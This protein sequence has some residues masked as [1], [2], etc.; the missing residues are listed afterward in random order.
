[1]FAANLSAAPLAN[2]L[3]VEDVFSTYLYTGNGSTQTIN[4]G[5]D[6]AGKGG[7]VWIKDR[8]NAYGHRLFN[9]TTGLSQ[10]LRSNSTGG[11]ATDTNALTALSSGFSATSNNAADAIT[12]NLSPFV[13]WT[14]RKAPKFFDVVTVSHTNGTPTNISLST[15]DTLG[16]VVAKITSTTGDWILWH[17]SLAAGNNLR[18][19]TTAAQTTTNAWLSVSGTTA[20]LSASAPT[21]TYVVYGFAHDTSVDGLIQCGSFTTDASG[22]ATV[23]LGWEPQF[24]ICKTSNAVNPWNMYDTMRGAPVSSVA[25]RLRA[26]DSTTEVDSDIVTPKADGFSISSY[27][28]STFVYLAIRR[29]PMKKPTSGTQVYQAVARTGTGAAAAVT[30]VGFP[31]DLV[32]GHE[33]NLASISSVFQDRLRGAGKLL[34]PIDTSAE[35]TYADTITAFGMDGASYG[36]DATLATINYSGYS[37]INWFLRRYPGVFDQVCWTGTDYASPT[38]PHNLGVV[39]ELQITKCRSTAGT[40]WDVQWIPNTAAP[41]TT[42]LGALNSTAAF[43]NSTP[44]YPSS[45]THFSKIFDDA[46][47][48]YTTYL[49]A[50]LPGISKVGSYVGN[51][52]SQTIDCG[53][54][55]GA[56]F[57]LVK[58]TDAVGNWYV[59]DTARGI[60]AGAEYD[61]SLNSTAAEGFS[62]SV[63]PTASGFI[64][65]QVAATNINVN[66][67]SYIYLAFS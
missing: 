18:L 49:F 64:V 33:R 52:T 9:T 67:A 8:V 35:S 16:Q 59:W 39:P 10:Y 32:I 15:L 12:S 51:G 19:N 22:N 30:G 21:G 50:T 36:A 29:G 55:A 7:L 53:F 62:D 42:K 27:A 34:L 56:R 2:S 44:T 17:R 31:P 65:N 61:L 43:T 26:N 60:F 28:S 11:L 66:G 24:L 41:A 37:Y 45:A 57:V 54:A 6:L 5:V 48:T 13:S 20:T 14:F 38:H 47:R 3:Y 40:A 4:N 63:D 46:G 23:N 1:M 25:K 58:R